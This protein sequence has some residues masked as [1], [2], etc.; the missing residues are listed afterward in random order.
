MAP[1]GAQAEIGVGPRGCLSE[2]KNMVF[3]GAQ[4]EIGVDPRGC[5][6]EGKYT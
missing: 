3:A 2:E 5:L 6:S 4:A 1:A